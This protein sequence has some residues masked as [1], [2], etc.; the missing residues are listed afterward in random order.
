MFREFYKDMDKEEVE[1]FFNKLKKSDMN[2]LD[3]DF[4]MG[5]ISGIL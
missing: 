2:N 5:G 1:K 3:M 4:P